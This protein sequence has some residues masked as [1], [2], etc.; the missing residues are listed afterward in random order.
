[1]KRQPERLRRTVG[2]LE[3]A[4]HGEIGL[5][6]KH[7]HARDSRYCLLEELQLSA[8]GVG[9]HGAQPRDIAARTGEA[10][11]E[12]T[13]HGVTA[14]RHDYGNRAARF[15]DGPGRHFTLSHDDI[16]LALDELGGESRQAARFTLR[17]SIFERHV[18][19]LHVAEIA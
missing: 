11:H 12:A 7:A 19:L 14:A 8:D 18:L 9:H 16:D 17:P 4:D 15:L 2:L 13:G 6:G 1:L 3:A 5:I 10:G